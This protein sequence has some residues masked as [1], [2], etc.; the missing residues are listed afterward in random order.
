MS[1]PEG[2]ELLLDESG[3]LAEC[4]RVIERG[5]GTFVE[6]GAALTKIRD[7][8]L[9]RADHVT[10]EDY[11][12]ERWG[13]SRVRAH[14][15]IDAAG[16]VGAL[17]IVNSDTPTLINEGQARAIAPTLKEHGPQF[18]AKVLQQ[19]A[20]VGL[21]AKS[22]QETAARAVATRMQAE[23]Q[24][25]QQAEKADA[26]MAD[27]KTR[28]ELDDIIDQLEA[29]QTLVVN[30]RNPI[31]TALHRAGYLT[32]IGRNTVWG[33]PFIL[34][35]DGTREQVID[36]YRDHYLPNKP[37]LIA[38]LNELQGRALGCWCAPLACHGDVLKAAVTRGAR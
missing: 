13:F 26:I 10:F 1:M 14:H 11:C 8:R 22:I 31:A 15:L 18:A 27:P 35:D 16:V 38:R 29:G 33:N 5:L 20:E 7:G 23:R 34:D 37:S 32:E 28:T 30:M 4:E 21:T 6:V 19:A 24:R 25:Q 12:R 36:A 3:E 9:Y 17:T 2:Q